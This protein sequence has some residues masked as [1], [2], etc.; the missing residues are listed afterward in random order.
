MDKF[1]PRICKIQAKR[2]VK[3]KPG[4]LYFFDIFVYNLLITAL[5]Y[6]PRA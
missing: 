6:S 2:L 1:D 4:G 3:F 5:D